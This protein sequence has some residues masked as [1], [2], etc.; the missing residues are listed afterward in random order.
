M[1]RLI[2]GISI[3]ISISF[4]ASSAVIFAEDNPP[5][6][7]E[8]HGFGAAPFPVLGYAPETSLMLGAGA[9]LYYKYPDRTTTDNINCV[10][11]YTLKK[12][13]KI[14]STMEAF[15]ADDHIRMKC[16]VSFARFPSEYFGIGPD[17]PESAKEKYTPE[18]FPL[19]YAFL[20]KALR[21]LYA[22][23]VYDFTYEKIVETESGKA[24]RGRAVPGSGK[25]R[26]SGFGGMIVYDTRD[27]AMNPSSGIYTE[28]RGIQYNKSVGSDFSFR[29]GY[30][31]IRNYFPI[32]NTVL[33]TQ[34]FS[35]VIT[36][37]APFYYLA[38]LGG[39]G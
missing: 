10:G 11:F 27:N 12:Q 2:V 23:P 5:V 22:G 33:C 3:I 13:Y 29:K 1:N 20:V 32:G 17:T 9:V 26:A 35:A 8:K 31:D 19:T 16:D 14:A 38:S 28:L 39:D 36:G 30:A 18:Y 25:T 37:K 24:L 21:G 7:N 4:F 34:L 6:E 15:F